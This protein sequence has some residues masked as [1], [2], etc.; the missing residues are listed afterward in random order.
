M[1]EVVGRDSSSEHLDPDLTGPRLGEILLHHL[2]HFRSAMT[3]H[4]NAM[5]LHTDTAPSAMAGSRIALGSGTAPLDTCLRRCIVCIEISS[6]VRDVVRS[7]PSHI[8]ARRI[9]NR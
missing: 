6:V 4:N 9:S 5:V 7:S 3:R 2:Q 8:I 1:H